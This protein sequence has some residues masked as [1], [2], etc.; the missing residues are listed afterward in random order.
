MLAAL[1]L[2]AIAEACSYAILSRICEAGYVTKVD[3]LG[4][5]PSLSITRAVGESTET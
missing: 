2:R 5:L 4:R 3:G 1:L